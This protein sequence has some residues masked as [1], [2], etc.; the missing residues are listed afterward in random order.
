MHSQQIDETT[1][2]MDF[3]LKRGVYAT[4]L[5]REMSGQYDS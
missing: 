5:L 2:E 3:K 4:T 1:I